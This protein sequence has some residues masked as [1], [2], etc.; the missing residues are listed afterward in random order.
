MPVSDLV[1]GGEGQY[2]LVGTKAGSIFLID[3]PLAQEACVN[4]VI[5]FPMTTLLLTLHGVHLAVAATYGE[6]RLFNLTDLLDFEPRSVLFYSTVSNKRRNIRTLTAISWGPNLQF[7]LGSDDHLVSIWSSVSDTV[8][9]VV[10]LTHSSTAIS[11]VTWREDKEVLVSCSVDGQVRVYATGSWELRLVFVASVDPF[12][13]VALS[14]E[15]D[16]MAACSKRGVI[17]V[18]DLTTH[19][20][21]SQL[22]THSKSS[23]RLF[24]SSH[25]LASVIGFN[26][27]QL[28]SI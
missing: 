15:G 11:D 18:F 26:S 6:I 5:S 3:Q 9:K 23:T 28:L 10:S 21:T 25:Y 17:S 1:W 19:K 4:E 8:T 16:M 14:G 22:F 20:R 24:W 7:A 13:R 27:L 12:V 2:I